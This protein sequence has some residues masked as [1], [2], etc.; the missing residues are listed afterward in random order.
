MLVAPYEKQVYSGMLPGVIAGHYRLDEALVDIAELCGRAFVE[1]VPGHVDALDLQARRARVDDGATIDYDAISLNPGSL[2]D[3]SLP[4][5]E[6]T[7]AAKPLEDFLAALDGRRLGRI[8]IVGGGVAGAE[9]AMAFVHRGAAVTLYSDR[10]TPPGPAGERI[11]Q[12]L[13]R[14]RVDFRP[15]MPATTVEDGPV[16]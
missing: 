9:L 2:V 7:L 5:A 15:G 1:F 3:D 14:K 6:R 11:A 16:V 12:A 4:G 8:A 13:R 10:P